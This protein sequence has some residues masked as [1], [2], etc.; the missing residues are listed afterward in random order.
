M[1]NN[2]FNLRSIY[3]TQVKKLRK[4]IIIASIQ[5]GGSMFVWMEYILPTLLG[6]RINIELF[7]IFVLLCSTT[8][9]GISCYII[10]KSKLEKAEIPK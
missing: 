5:W 6:E 1:I 8:F 3:F 10:A 9:F 4:Q 7:Q 2:N